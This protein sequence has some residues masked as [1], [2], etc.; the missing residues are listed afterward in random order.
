MPAPRLS[1][2]FD[3]ISPN[4]YI[5]WTQVHSLAARHGH[6]VDAVPVL[7]AGLLS[8]NRA[9]GPAE[10]RNKWRW[11]VRDIVRKAASLRIPLVPPTS[12]PFNP[13]LALRLAS[14]DMPT[15]NR[16][17]LI[18][19]LFEAIWA[20]GPGVTDPDV[21]SQVLAERGFDGPSLVRAAGS[22]QVK[23]A[24]R[25]QT[26]AA[27]KKQ[28]FGVPSVIVG[29]RL[30]WGY[31]DFPHLEAHLAGGDAFDPAALA[32]WEAVPPSAGRK[33]QGSH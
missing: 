31:D 18:D 24:L 2:I 29:D 21:V 26:E 22:D 7:F 25:R 28:V 27:V 30:F 9:L 15:E 16:R 19:V 5:A 14:L 12:H 23:L 3:F 20:G 8:A 10:V 11:M 33:I 13:L 17:R 4:A 6:A 32:V 1:F